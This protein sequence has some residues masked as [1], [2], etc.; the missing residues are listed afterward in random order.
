[1]RVREGLHNWAH[2]FRVSAPAWLQYLY[3]LRFS[4]LLTLSLPVL[5][6][7]DYTNKTSSITRGIFALTGLR[8]GIIA[9]AFVL[10]LNLVTFLI[11]R[12][13]CV[14]GMDRFNTEPP[15]LLGDWFGPRCGMVEDPSNPGVLVQ[16]WQKTLP[17]LCVPLFFTILTDGYLWLTA[18]REY[19]TQAPR[20]LGGLFVGTVVC[21]A[22]WYAISLFYYWLYD[23]TV[24]ACHPKPLIFPA[25]WCGNLVELPHLRLFVLGNALKT[26][27][28]LSPE[29]YLYGAVMRDAD[30][31]II[32]DT[33][34]STRRAARAA[35]RVFELHFF[36]A[37]A[38][39]G[40]FGIYLSLYSM[41]A[42]IYLSETKLVLALC[43]FLPALYLCFVIARGQVKLN[44]NAGPSTWGRCTKLAFLVALGALLA[45]VFAQFFL[46]ANSDPWFRLFFPRWFPVL[47]SVLV[48]T[49]FLTWLLGG[50]AF[51]LDRFRIP[52]L[53]TFLVV[54]LAID[55]T[56]VGAEHYFEASRL[57]NISKLPTPDA[58]VA[59][60]SDGHP[61]IVV[62]GQ[63]G[64]IHAAAWT[65]NV[66]GALEE[67]FEIAKAD[68]FH[69][70]VLLLSSVSGSS[71]AAL[72]FLREFDE[73]S[74][75][76]DQ[77]SYK[78]RLLDS[79]QCSSLPAVAWGLEYRDFANL[80]L[81]VF[82]SS[83][84]RSQ[85]LEWAF[86]RNLSDI[87]CTPDTT[88]WAAEATPPTLATAVP[89]DLAAAAHYLPAF[90]MNTTVAEDGDRFLLANYKVDKLPADINQV[91]GTPITTVPAASF[92]DVYNQNAGGDVP[93]DQQANILLAT[94]ARLSATFPY[95]S[96]A[97]RIASN[98]LTTLRCAR[99]AS[100]FVDGG[101]FD[102]DGTATAIEFLQHAFS[103]STQAN[104]SPRRHHHRDTQWRRPGCK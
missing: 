2:E 69:T 19:Q 18:T 72:S 83:R 103:A 14:N 38:L 33:D 9:S 66:L 43:P 49:T 80:F 56:S 67:R 12:I 3:F 29:G 98:A 64:G 5:C 48:L 92:L 30:G 99:G 17:A 101:Y 90:S 51:F 8:D 26:L 45:L 60:F 96:S 91:G 46:S 21:L 88:P 74:P 62:T 55:L 10:N 27:F 86:E 102:N 68:P 22:C 13:V 82:P 81:P 6:C 36:A 84:D 61:M 76:S 25:A 15:R 47:A 37:I 4:I 31:D 44:P 32:N 16:R 54:I 28:S 93:Q 39:L 75:F 71:V 42:P 95:V 59:H 73:P 63:G 20:V 78:A 57:P 35:R 40:F 100:H 34:G 7:L 58:F 23:G 89:K 65:A 85:A 104:T 97:G 24:D 41:I 52:V 1:M 79:A 94:A 77:Q 50:L 11:A 70:R 87:D 53:T